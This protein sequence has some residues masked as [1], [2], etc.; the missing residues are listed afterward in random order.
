MLH[1]LALMYTCISDIKDTIVQALA[2]F[3]CYPISLK[4]LESIPE[5]G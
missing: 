5:A 4:A 2:C 3:V 1:V